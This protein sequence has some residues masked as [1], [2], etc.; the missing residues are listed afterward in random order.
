MAVTG[1]P[2][3]VPNHADMMADFAFDIIR[4]MERVKKRKEK[5]FP[6]IVNLNVR[7]GFHSGPVIAGVVR[8]DRG[9][10]QLFGDT[11]R[12]AGIMEQK[13]EPGK[14]HVSNESAKL[15]RER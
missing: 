10:F 8:G 7:V 15:L 14:I 11:V 12:I 9:R 3:Q 6:D 5:K 1:I 2:D 4:C 13:S